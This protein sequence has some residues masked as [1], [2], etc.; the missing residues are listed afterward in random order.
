MSQM[1]CGAHISSTATHKCRKLLRMEYA[2]VFRT[3]CEIR[4]HRFVYVCVGSGLIKVVELINNQN[5]TFKSVCS[6]ENA[7]LG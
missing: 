7:N 1:R 5:V 4:K 2:Y 6:L 3:M